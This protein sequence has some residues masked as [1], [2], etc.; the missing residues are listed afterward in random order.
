LAPSATKPASPGRSI[1][2]IEILDRASF[3]EVP[4]DE[5]RNVVTA[6]RNT[7]IR[8]KKPKIEVAQPAGNR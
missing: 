8:G 6:L 2:T 3:V 5:A 7:Q 4:S 1:G